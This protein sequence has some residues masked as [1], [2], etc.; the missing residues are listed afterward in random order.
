MPLLPDDVK[1]QVRET[2]AD[3]QHPVH[4]IV[5]TQTIECAHC[6]DNRQLLEEVAELSDLIDVQVYNLIVD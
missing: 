6:Q 4:L 3:L 5:F 1:K 2:F